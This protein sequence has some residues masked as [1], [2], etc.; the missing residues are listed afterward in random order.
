MPRPHR[1]DIATPQRRPAI[2]SGRP[3]ASPAII[4]DT[5]SATV[6]FIAREPEKKRAMRRITRMVGGKIMIESMA[7]LQVPLRA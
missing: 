6:A 1:N 7:G 2:G 5:V 3:L 4:G